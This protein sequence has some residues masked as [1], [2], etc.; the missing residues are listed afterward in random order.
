MKREPADLVAIKRKDGL[1]RD[2]V[3]TAVKR[4]PPV[5]AVATVKREAVDVSVVKREPA[6]VTG[7]PVGSRSGAAED[8][9]QLKHSKLFSPPSP[10][11]KVRI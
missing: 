3:D 4:E 7:G 5:D 8:E 6:A 10:E 11:K 2:V 1:K 9:Y